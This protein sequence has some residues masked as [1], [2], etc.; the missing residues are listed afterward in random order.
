MQTEARGWW[1]GISVADTVTLLALLGFCAWAIVQARAWPFRAALFPVGT[2]VFMVLVMLIRLGTMVAAA[3]Q[4]EAPRPARAID[5]MPAVVV[6]DEGVLVEEDAA[7]EAEAG[8]IFATASRSLWAQSLAWMGGFFL[9]SWLAGM[10][11]AIPTFTLAYLLIESR[12]R[13]IV[14]VTYAVISGL[15][16]FGLF[17]QLL[18]IP[19]PT[20]AVMGF[21]GQ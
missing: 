3:R 16:I 12:E 15:F 14:A 10:M 11:V 5:S 20:S 17:D 1:R 18:H 6:G 7:A 21:V 9:L 13:P 19:L 4:D 8:D 2:A